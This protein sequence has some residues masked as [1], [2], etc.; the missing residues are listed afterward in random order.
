MEPSNGKTPLS[1]TPALRQAKISL[2]LGKPIFPSYRVRGPGNP[3]ILGLPCQRNGHSGSWPIIWTRTYLIQW[4]SLFQKMVCW[5]EYPI[6]LSLWLCGCIL[7]D[8]R[9]WY[10]TVK[11]APAI[12]RQTPMSLCYLLQNLFKLV[13][14]DTICP[15]HLISLCTKAWPQYALDNGT[16]WPLQ[17][18]S[19]FVILQVDR[20]PL[21]TRFL[22]IAFLP[23]PHSNS[24]VSLDC[25]A[26]KFLPILELGP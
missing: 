10:R 20:T 6:H 1:P 19:E 5:M 4:E 25:G 23:F 9:S 12:R 2:R 16:W 8:F 11:W 7:L 22:D 18:S 13:L 17:G 15:E 14:S 24:H 26:S 3:V 21:F